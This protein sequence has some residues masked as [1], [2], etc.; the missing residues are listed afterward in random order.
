MLTKSLDSRKMDN[1]AKMGSCATGVPK[2]DEMRWGRNLKMTMLRNHDSGQNRTVQVECALPL[3]DVNTDVPRFKGGGSESEAGQ[4]EP[5]ALD[6]GGNAPRTIMKMQIC[7][8]S[9]RIS[10]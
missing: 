6:I 10:H 7:Q 1:E 4:E 3:Q 2:T 9:S 8:H 5:G